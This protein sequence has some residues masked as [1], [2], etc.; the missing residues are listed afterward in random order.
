MG[1]VKRES[2]QWIIG[3]VFEGWMTPEEKRCKAE[4]QRQLD[5]LPDENVVPVSVRR[6][7]HQTAAGPGQRPPSAI[8]AP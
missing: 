8:S 6:Y 3:Q 2:I 5:A 4:F 7:H 1:Y